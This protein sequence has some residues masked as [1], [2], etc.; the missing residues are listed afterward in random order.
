MVKNLVSLKIME[1][2]IQNSLKKIQKNTRSVNFEVPE[3]DETSE[4]G[5]FAWV[6]IEG[7]G[8]CRGFEPIAE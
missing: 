2:A 1:V 7:D 3:S 8:D 5:G 6:E 4:R